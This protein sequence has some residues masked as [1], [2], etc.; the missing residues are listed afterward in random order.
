MSSDRV[1][2]LESVI[3]RLRGRA[4]IWVMARTPEEAPAA[5][6][7]L[8]RGADHVV[9][10]VRNSDDVARLNELVGAPETPPLVWELVPIRRVEP[11]GLGDRVI[12]DTTSLLRPQEG[13]LVGSSAAFLFH[14]VSEAVGSE[15]SRPRPFRVNAGSGHS[16]V[17]LADGTTRY[18]TELSPGDAVLVADPAG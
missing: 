3:S 2:P 13:L 18:L 15:F 9:V 10:E 4:N 11:V 14:V 6:G 5:M 12:V 7:A 8:E 16:Y 1:I 17:L